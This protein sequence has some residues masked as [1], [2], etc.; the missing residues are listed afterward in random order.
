V[1]ED[2]V[3]TKPGIVDTKPS[4]AAKEGKIVAQLQ[5]EIREVLDERFFQG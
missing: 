3:D 1:K 4:L 2:E 5:E